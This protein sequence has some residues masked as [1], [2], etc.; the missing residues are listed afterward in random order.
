MEEQYENKKCC[1][2]SCFYK[3]I[4][5]FVLAIVMLNITYFRIHS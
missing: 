4:V 1:A 5:E 3:V 2:Y